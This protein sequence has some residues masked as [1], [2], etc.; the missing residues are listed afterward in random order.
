[1]C[2]AFGAQIP[3]VT[4]ASAIKKYN[5]CFVKISRK[6]CKRLSTGQ[7]YSPIGNAGVSE[8]LP[9]AT[10]LIHSSEIY[11]QRNDGSR[12]AHSKDHRDI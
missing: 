6:G 7:D 5:T 4:N 10:T 3:D 12:T 2:S 1:M 8:D 11:R 9:T